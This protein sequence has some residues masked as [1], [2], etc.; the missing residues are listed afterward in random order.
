MLAGKNKFLVFIL[1]LSYTL[2]SSD[3]RVGLLPYY[4]RVKYYDMMQQY[5]RWQDRNQW[6]QER[7]L[8]T[9]DLSK[10]L[11]QND[12]EKYEKNLRLYGE[13]VLKLKEQDI[14]YFLSKEERDRYY[15]SLS[16]A[17]KQYFSYADEFKRAYEEAR[18]RSKGKILE[19]FLKETVVVVVTA[20][21]TVLTGGA[22][23]PLLSSS[24]VSFGVD[25]MHSAYTYYNLENRG[26][27]DAIRWASSEEYK[28][29]Q[30]V[31]ASA[32]VTLGFSSG[33][34]SF[35]DPLTS[36]N[37]AVSIVSVGSPY[38]NQDT[39]R[40]I[41]L[42][43]ASMGAYSSFRSLTTSQIDVV[44]Q[45][46]SLAESINPQYSNLYNTAVTWQNV[47]NTAQMVSNLAQL[48]SSLYAVYS[49]LSQ[50]P[51]YEDYTYY[52]RL[53]GV[54]ASG[55]SQVG[56]HQAVTNT[57]SANEEI[58]RQQ[59]FAR[60]NVYNYNAN[61]ALGEY[62]QP[63]AYKYYQEQVARISNPFVKMNE[64]LKVMYALRT[65]QSYS[66][67]QRE[68]LFDTYFNKINDNTNIS[69]FLQRRK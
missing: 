55:V 46:R 56:Y 37:S 41:G 2:Y 21:V 39:N 7:Y 31:S 26:V 50:N 53:A 15:S 24:L 17:G 32:K 62:Q 12:P 69:N 30:L 65:Q 1:L 10:S 42:A 68:S 54:V 51:M 33:Q 22:T 40:V 66:Q 63:F 67:Q 5:R 6:Y 25:T 43:Q 14:P 8:S 20:A 45:S 29:S 52:T 35:S 60:L 27:Y 34:L 59:G 38:Y 47:A 11:Q 13:R 4:Q 58:I 19:N 48:S 44:S 18:E 57:L 61:I 23:M 49:N 64:S 9:I 36:L 28:F 3:T 16:E